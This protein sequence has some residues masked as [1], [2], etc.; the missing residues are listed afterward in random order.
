MIN[1]NSFVKILK[2]FHEKIEV[3]NK[4]VPCTTSEMLLEA[5][6]Q[7]LLTFYVSPG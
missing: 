6:S 3:I 4:T 2:H 1:W 5:T 7:M